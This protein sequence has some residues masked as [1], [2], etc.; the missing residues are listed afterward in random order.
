MKCRCVCP[1]RCACGQVVFGGMLYTSA[2]SR[3]CLST[4]LGRDNTLRP[5][6]ATRCESLGSNKTAKA[7]H[8]GRFVNPRVKFPQIHGHKL[9]G[10]DAEP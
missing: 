8:L 3:A 6:V 9:S 7:A 2:V 1:V 5:Q 10:R 4:I